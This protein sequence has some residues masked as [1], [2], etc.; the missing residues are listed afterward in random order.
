MR[1]PNPIIILLCIYLSTCKDKSAHKK[2]I[3]AQHINFIELKILPVTQNSTIEIGEILWFE[4]FDIIMALGENVS[5]PYCFKVFSGTIFHE[6]SQYS[7]ILLTQAILSDR[8]I[9]S[10]ST[11]LNHHVLSAILVFLFIFAG[12]LSQMKWKIIL[13]IFSAKPFGIGNNEA[14]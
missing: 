3:T 2:L 5:P 13:L 4:Q 6:A 10:K 11:I 14:Q 12:L 7:V 9:I 1:T 8:S